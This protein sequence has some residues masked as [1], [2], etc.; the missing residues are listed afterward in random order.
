MVKQKEIPKYLSYEM[1][2]VKATPKKKRR[3]EMNFSFPS[4][5]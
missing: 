4:Q 3:L 2:L 1:S 5:F